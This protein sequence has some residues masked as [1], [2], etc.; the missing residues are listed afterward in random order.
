MCKWE[1]S[2]VSRGCPNAAD[3]SKRAALPEKGCRNNAS[4]IE[5]WKQF[6]TMEIVSLIL[7]HINLKINA[8]LDTLDQERKPYYAFAIGTLEKVKTCCSKCDNHLCGKHKFAI[9]QTCFENK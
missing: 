2:A 8:F 5:I 6:I 1:K 9:C 3:A 4:I 7:H